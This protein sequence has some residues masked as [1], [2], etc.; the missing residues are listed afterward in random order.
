MAGVNDLSLGIPVGR[1]C[2][3]YHII[4]DTLMANGIRPV[5]QSTLFQ[6]GNPA[7]NKNIGYLND[8]LEAYC[9]EKN[10]LF[11]DLNRTMSD[12]NG[13]LQELTT[14]GTHLSELGY[15]VWSDKLKWIISELSL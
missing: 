9:Y 8:L 4:I 11:I 3:N 7:G 14:D 2:A 6:T 15:E 1:V 5:V 12:H 10:I 13:L